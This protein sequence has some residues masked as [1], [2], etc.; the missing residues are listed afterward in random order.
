MFETEFYQLLASGTALQSLLGNSV[1]PAVQRADNTTGIF[2]GT[3]PEEAPLP[4]VEWKIVSDRSIDTM[5]G[6]NRTSPKRVQLNVYASEYLA[7][8]QVAAAVCALLGGY[9]GVLSQGGYLSGVIRNGV[10][11]VFEE[12]PLLY[13]AIINY[14]MMYTDNG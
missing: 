2:P 4:G 13:R 8:K 9:R 11:D 5:E 10:S 12:K 1:S 6:V 3:W 14:S 7:C